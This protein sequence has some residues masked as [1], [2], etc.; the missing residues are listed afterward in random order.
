MQNI[1]LSFFCRIFLVESCHLRYV[2]NVSSFNLHFFDP[3]KCERI[4]FKREDVLEHAV[5]ADFAECFGGLIDRFARA[6]FARDH[7]VVVRVAEV[8]LDGV[9]ARGHTL[10]R[11]LADDGLARGVDDDHGYST[12]VLDRDGA[13]FRIARQSL[14]DRCRKALAAKVVEHFDR[15]TVRCH[16]VAAVL[17]EQELRK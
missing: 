7:V 4:L 11:K 10:D 16:S 2:T 8:T 5:L 9:V 3:V 6:S 14:A 12:L 1:S 17:A 13:I 15:N